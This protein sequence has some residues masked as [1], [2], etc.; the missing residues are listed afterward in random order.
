MEIT[1]TSIAKKSY[2]KNIEFLLKIWNLKVAQDF[3]LDVEKAMEL[4]SLQPEIFEE[5]EFNKNYRKGF[6]HKNV[7]FYYKIKPTEL[8]V[9]LFWNNLQDPNKIKNILKKLN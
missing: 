9:Y 5:W 4:I 1:W 8:V 7:S 2:V 3:I 6:I